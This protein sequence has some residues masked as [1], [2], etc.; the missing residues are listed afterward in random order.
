[1]KRQKNTMTVSI[2]AIMICL[3]S[4][5]C[6]TCAVAR[7]YSHAFLVSMGVSYR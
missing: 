7:I 2:M 4:N 3:G 1:M 6:L 5:C